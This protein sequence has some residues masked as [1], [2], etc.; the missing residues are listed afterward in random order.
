MRPDESDSRP[1]GNGPATKSLNDDTSSVSATREFDDMLAGC[2][3]PEDPTYRAASLLSAAWEPALSASYRLGREDGYAAGHAAAEAEMAAAWHRV[4]VD[5]K[6]VLRQPTL[7]E[8]RRRR[9]G[10]AA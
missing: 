10:A 8:L 1:A 2:T 7:D 3:G 5:V 6:N 4:Y 9:T